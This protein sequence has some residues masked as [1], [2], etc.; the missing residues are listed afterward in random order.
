MQA[1]FE[2]TEISVNKICR[3]LSD[4][5]L[6]KYLERFGSDRAE[7]IQL[8]AYNTAVSEALYTPLQGLEIA[9]R[10]AIDIQLVNWYGS[11]WHL[12]RN[13]IF[14]Q[15]LIQMIDGAD[16]EV[17]REKSAPSRGDII[18]ELNFGFWTTVLSQRYD[19]PLWR[20]T[21]RHAFPN[22]PRGFRRKN[23]H[24]AINAIRRLRNRVMHHE[25][26][27]HRDLQAD[28]DTI[29]EIVSWICPETSRW[30]SSQSRFSQVFRSLELPATS[31]SAIRH[32]VALGPGNSN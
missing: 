29:I 2:Y 30:V 15:P 19:D 18:A 31:A 4:D 21:T 17:R 12:D 22:L 26:I 10:N 23:V 8:Y 3:L 6:R 24:K 28:H 11:N 25:P 16:M 5:R 1:V 14:E 13:R 20:E 7:C 9:L 27:L 32:A